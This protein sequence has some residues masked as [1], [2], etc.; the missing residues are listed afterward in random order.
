MEYSSTFSAI[1]PGV[2][3]VSG[4]GG[5]G[6]PLPQGSVQSIL[7]PLNV[8]K[9]G[10]AGGLH[11]TV[12]DRQVNRVMLIMSR[13]GVGTRKPIGE[14]ALDSDGVLEESDHIS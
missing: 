13:L 12:N 4:L 11:V 14:F 2:R 7:S 6:R 9:H 3:F 10:V 5:D 8:V 1:D